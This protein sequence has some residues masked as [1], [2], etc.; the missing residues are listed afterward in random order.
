VS[1]DREDG[2]AEIVITRQFP[3]PRALVFDAWTKPER[4][5][6]WFGPTGFT[7][8]VVRIDLR[9]GGV[10]VSCMRGPDGKDYWSRG[11][12]R[13]V[14]V[15]ARI[16]CTD[17]FADADGNIVEP[18]QYGMSAGWPREALLTVTFTE[19]H[20][21]TTLRLRHAVGTAPVAERDMCQRGW[22]ESL[23]KL[24]AYLATA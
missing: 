17:S 4:M 6:Q 13:E 7:T 3:A 20:G 14:D 11:V 1:E 19:D 9:P 15:P 22:S 16:V 8:P 21:A 2:R 18:T 23:D 12:Y 24:A 5:A 10:V